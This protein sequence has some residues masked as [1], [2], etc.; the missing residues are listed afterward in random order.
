MADRIAAMYAGKVVEFGPVGEVLTVP[1]H[2][3][4]AALLTS[5]VL[6]TEPGKPIP[7]IDG[8]PPT[9]PGVFAPCAFAPRCP[10]ADAICWSEEPRY[11]WPAE[12]GFACHHP[13]D[14]AVAAT[15]GSVA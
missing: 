3:Y 10:R 14:E 12:A 5:S 4:P 9:L 1:R 8:Q 6:S 13:R 7:T 15:L 2:H 11:A